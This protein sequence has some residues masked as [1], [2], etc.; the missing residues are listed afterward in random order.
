MGVVLKAFYLTENAYDQIMQ[1]NPDTL[2]TELQKIEDRKSM[3]GAHELGHI[4]GLFD[5]DKC[6]SSSNLEDHHEELLMGYGYGTRVIR[7]T[8]KDIAGVSITR[9]FHTDADHVWMLRENRNEETDAFESYDVICA[10]CNGVRFNVDDD[11]EIEGTNY[12]YLGEEIE[13]FGSCNGEHNITG[14]NMLLVATDMVRDFYK[15]LHCRYIEEA[16]HTNH[17][18]SHQWKKYDNT[19]HIEQCGC[20]ATGTH[21]ALH[22]IRASEIELGKAPCIGCGGMIRISPIDG[23]TPVIQN[24][25]KVSINGSYILPNG[26]IVLVDEDVEA[27]YNGTLVFYDKDNLPQTE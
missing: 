19:Y 23:F 4:L 9:G 22:A 1:H 12:Y 16:E 7:P 2:Q 15:C 25:Q 14:E 3:V 10:L 26:V 18:Y 11:I 27:Y 8:Y 17:V 13:L 5:V 20:G 24:V 21:K 6:C